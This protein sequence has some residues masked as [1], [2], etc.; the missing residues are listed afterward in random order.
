MRRRR[1]CWSSRQRAPTPPRSLRRCT[2]LEPMPLPLLADVSLPFSWRVHACDRCFVS[3]LLGTLFRCW[4]PE[5]MQCC[6][7][8]YLVLPLHSRFSLQEAAAAADALGRAG[9]FAACQAVLGSLPAAAVLSLRAGLPPPLQAVT[10]TPFDF[11][12]R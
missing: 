8:A 9:A 11:V 2:A 5:P 6:R 10:P 3:P 7:I 4:N 12:T 1:C